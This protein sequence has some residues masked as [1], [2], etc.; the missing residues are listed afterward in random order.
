MELEI[1]PVSRAGFVLLLVSFGCISCPPVEPACRSMT[2]G[3]IINDSKFE[4]A[5]GSD[6]GH[7]KQTP[8]VDYSFC[9][10]ND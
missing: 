2:K 8:P 3:L 9:R 6:W 1:S 10:L 5:K 4:M 7:G